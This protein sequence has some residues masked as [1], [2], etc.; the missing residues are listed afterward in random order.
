MIPPPKLING[1]PI[2][3]FR[4]YIGAAVDAV[5]LGFM[6]LEGLESVVQAATIKLAK[7][8]KASDKWADIER[9]LAR[10][11]QLIN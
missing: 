10:A 6:D 5:R 1:R 8:P 3:F 9:D 11:E 7:V 4:T 2:V